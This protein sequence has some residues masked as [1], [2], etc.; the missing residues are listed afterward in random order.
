MPPL[1]SSKVSTPH[2]VR[3]YA[4]SA[5]RSVA[6]PLQ[7]SGLTIDS[8]THTLICVICHSCV[9]PGVAGT[10]GSSLHGLKK[11][12]ATECSAL[13]DLLQRQG[14]LEVPR[15]YPF[16]WGEAPVESIT[17]KDGFICRPCHF[18]SPSN[19][20]IDNHRW[21]PEHQSLSAEDTIRPAEHARIQSF[22]RRFKEQWFLVVPA[23]AGL[24]PEDPYSLY[25][26]QYSDRGDASPW[27]PL[28]SR[29]AL[30]SYS[31]LLT[32]FEAVASYLN[33]LS[34][35]AE[36]DLGRFHAF[37]TSFL[38]AR[39]T[40][41]LQDKFQHPLQCLLAIE[42][43]RDDGNTDDAAHAVLYEAEVAAV[44]DG[45]SLDDAVHRLALE[46][47]ALN[48]PSP[49]NTVVDLQQFVSSLA[50]RSVRPPTTRVS[51][52]GM[53]ITHLEHVLDVSDY[54]QG[55]RDALADLHRRL[56]VLCYGF[57]LSFKLPEH[58]IDDW[59]NKERGYGFVDNY[60]Y[61]PEDTLFSHL[62]RL[63]AAG[64]SRADSDGI[65]RFSSA[66]VEKLLAE[67]ADF[68]RMLAPFVASTASCSRIAEFVDAK[69]RNSTW[70]CTLFMH[71]IDLWLVTRR[72]KWE[73]LVRHEVF[74]PHLILP[75]VAELLLQY[76]LI[77]CPVL[78]KLVHIVKGEELALLYSEYLWVAN[79]ERI[80][81]DAFSPLL[82]S[83]TGKF[84]RVS[85]TPRI[86]RHMQVE[87]FRIFLNSTAELEEED[88]DLL[89]VQRG[90]SHPIAT[91]FYAV[92]QGCLPTLSSDSLL[93]HCTFCV[94][95]SQVI[96][97]RP[98]FAPLAPI[99]E[100][101]RLRQQQ[102]ELL[103]SAAAASSPPSTDA[104]LVRLASEIHS[105]VSHMIQQLGS[106]LAAETK[107]N[108]VQAVAEAIRRQ[109]PVLEKPIDIDDSV[110]WDC[111]ALT[112]HLLRCFYQRTDASF[113]SDEQRAAIHAALLGHKSFAAC[114]PPGAG[115]SLTYLLPVEIEPTPESV[116]SR[117]NCYSFALVGT[118][119]P[120]DPPLA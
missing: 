8:R 71:G 19:I 46:N 106:R 26:R 68:Q 72:M 116:T 31:G 104:Q 90:H 96:S 56:S 81:S 47:I 10:H 9:R 38:L 34:L 64:L 59:T 113:R 35:S 119:F 50:Y 84:C 45:I 62:L 83:F 103:T 89:A 58:V 110:P 21:S 36:R 92:E 85:L 18:A 23:A 52:N 109:A 40:H 77:F 115:K 98:G 28:S 4:P 79:G 7:K 65:L 54:R 108:V 63:E 20:T 16:P 80:S 117:H 14:A 105:S 5:I 61:V 111:R 88:E 30:M 87:M 78:V 97:F 76:I 101:H 95:W 15:D 75:E 67:D 48:A 12:S 11:L 13:A 43:L 33:V 24:S 44:R 69:L 29:G 60:R 86:H 3:P 114:L 39:P 22:F 27:Q 118:V 74:V 41:N 102:S 17:S 99:I 55:L 70:P 2:R 32:Q 66:A 82:A 112:L 100:R 37:V 53:V 107:A 25:L 42:T 73:N 49:H 1:G 93:R 57:P 94:D 51:P 6:D 120:P 91:T